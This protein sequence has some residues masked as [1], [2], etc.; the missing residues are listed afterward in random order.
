MDEIGLEFLKLRSHLVI[1]LKIPSCLYKKLEFIE[2][3]IALNQII[4]SLDQSD[5]MT[6]FA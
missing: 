1:D 4:M 6:I 2:L 3:G 5:P